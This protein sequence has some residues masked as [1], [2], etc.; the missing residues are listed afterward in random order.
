MAHDFDRQ[1]EG[2]GPLDIFIMALYRVDKVGGRMGYGRQR[3]RNKTLKPRVYVALIK[4]D[5]D[6]QYVLIFSALFLTKVKV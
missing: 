6:L 2:E 3:S 4:R 1:D 5:S